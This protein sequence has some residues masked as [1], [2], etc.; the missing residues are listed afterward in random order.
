MA[1]LGVQERFEEYLRWVGDRGRRPRKEST[2]REEARLAHWSRR[3]LYPSGKSYRREWDVMVKHLVAG[4]PKPNKV[5]GDT[6]KEEIRAFLQKHGHFPS[7]V[8]K[9]A[10]EEERRLGRA[11]SNYVDRMG[12]SYSPSFRRE[13]M[14][15][16]YAS[17]LRRHD[18]PVGDE[19]A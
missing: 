3:W 6:T 11:L 1:D 12:T 16:G 18:G 14:A 15:L 5:R 17:R 4:K 10:T 2:D 8:R 13:V 19:D 7:A 9:D